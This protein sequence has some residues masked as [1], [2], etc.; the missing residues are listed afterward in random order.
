VEAVNISNPVVR[1]RGDGIM[2][3]LLQ[4][5]ELF[6]L[7]KINTYLFGNVIVVIAAGQDIMYINVEVTVIQKFHLLF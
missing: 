3:R 1:I 2:P 6:N 7:L 5:L 4:I